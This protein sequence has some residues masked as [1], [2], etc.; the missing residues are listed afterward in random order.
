[1]HG[2]D[3]I[4]KYL[5]SLESSIKTQSERQENAVIV[6]LSTKEKKKYRLNKLLCKPNFKLTT[7]STT[8]AYQ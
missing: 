1:M 8:D 5:L 6:V 3:D 4:D 7:T 2:T